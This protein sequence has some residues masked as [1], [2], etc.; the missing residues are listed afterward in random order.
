[1]GTNTEID[2]DSQVTSWRSGA[3]VTFNCTGCVAEITQIKK[4]ISFLL[5]DN[6]KNNFFIKMSD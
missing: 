2:S 3:E 1:M 5:N 4:L 6:L